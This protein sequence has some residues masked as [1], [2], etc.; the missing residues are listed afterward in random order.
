M[1]TAAVALGVAALALLSPLEHKLR[2][3]EVRD[4]VAT[5]AQ[6]RSAFSELGPREMTRR[7]PELRHI[8][9]G[10]AR[11]TGARIALLDAK[12]RVIVDTDP[13][14]HD[15]FRDF[16]A[17]LSTSRAV[18]RIVPSG[19]AGEARVA[20]RV[21]AGDRRFVLALRKPLDEQRSA[22]NSVRR[23]F[24]TAALAALG[25]AFVLATGVAAAVLGRLRRLR[26]AVVRLGAPGFTEADIPDDRRGDEIGDL[27]RAFADMHGRLARQEE[28]RRMFVATASHE[29]RTPL[30]SLQGQLEMLDEDLS[31]QAPDV[32]D[33]RRQLA[34]ARTQADRLTRLATDL[35]D[36]SRLDA[37]PDL[38]REPVE[39]RELVRAVAAEFE[40]AAGARQVRIETSVADACDVAADPVAVARVVRILIDNA[41][42]FSPPGTSIRIEARARAGSVELSVADS[43]PGVAA[44]ERERIFERFARGDDA[45][46]AGFGLGLAIGRELAAR[47]GGTLGLGDDHSGGAVF[48]LR[49]PG[50]P[51]RPNA[52]PT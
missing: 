26:N 52:I 9:R 37:R 43:G 48:V 23:A 24:T 21:L 28:L 32:A 25:A 44:D 10:L 35:L 50:A 36:L 45:S 4:L 29:L 27:S 2:D 15:A 7:A 13:D 40:A 5:A 8:V 14:E 42:R 1:L 49:L 3:Q 34:G 30:M 20:V 18:R 11:A 41:L 39:L 47:M 19:A 31:P 46:G 22:V 38:R 12:R 16:Y 33:A 6:S 17:A 51:A